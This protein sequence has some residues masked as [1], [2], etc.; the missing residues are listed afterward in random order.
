[1]TRVQIPAA[2]FPSDSE[3]SDSWE[4]RI[5]WQ[6]FLHRYSDGRTISDE[7]RLFWKSFSSKPVLSNFAK[8]Y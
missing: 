7:E 2:A 6:F 8:K 1:M 3:P 4:L 5:F